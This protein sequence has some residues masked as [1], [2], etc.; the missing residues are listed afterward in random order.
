MSVRIDPE[1][2][3]GRP[4]VRGVET[5]VL[6]DRFVAGEHIAALCDD[7]DLSADEVEDALRYELTKR[8]KHPRGMSNDDSRRRVLE[9]NP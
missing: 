4:Q 2:R 6:R 8:R 3:F 7:Y 9:T 5:W 1:R